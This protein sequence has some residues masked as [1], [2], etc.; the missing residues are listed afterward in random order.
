MTLN[1]KYMYPFIRSLCIVGNIRDWGHLHRYCIQYAH[2]ADGTGLCVGL[3]S[4]PLTLSRYSNIEPIF[5]PTVSKLMHEG[6]D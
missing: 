6:H 4:M 2:L 1:K 3:I 5:I